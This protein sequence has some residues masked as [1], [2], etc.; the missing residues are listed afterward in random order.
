M[1]HAHEG[2]LQAYLDG[3]V[4]GAARQEIA[5][6]VDA[7]A[8]CAADLDALRG[9]SAR[10]SAALAAIDRPI[11]VEPA[12]REARARTTAVRRIQPHVAR[13]AAGRGPGVRRNFVRAAVLTLLLAGGASAAIPGTPVRQWLSG[14]WDRVATFFGGERPEPVVEV[15]EQ[16]L[17]AEETGLTIAPYQGRVTIL[18]TGADPAATIHVVLVDQP[19]ASVVATSPGARFGTARGRIEVAEIGQ[20]DLIVRIPVTLPAAVVELNGRLVASKTGAALVAHAPPLRMSQT[21]L[22]FG[23][24]PD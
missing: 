2:M 7:C 21:E 13:S 17:A 24:G 22:V 11:A 12:L 10:F 18:L 16:P 19:T 5:E 23:P 3:E 14:A 1:N 4:S 9:L 20:R 8:S 6:H 15:R